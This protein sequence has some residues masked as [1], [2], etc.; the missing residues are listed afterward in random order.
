MG[1]EFRLSG[2][3]VGEGEEEGGEGR[4]VVEDVLGSTKT[5]VEGRK[6]G[7]ILLELEFFA[8][9]SPSSSLHAHVINVCTLMNKC[10]SIHT[11]FSP[12]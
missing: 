12:Q 6:G 3:G 1:G 9:V 5:C 7:N 11:Q 2:V 10:C 8:R 4:M